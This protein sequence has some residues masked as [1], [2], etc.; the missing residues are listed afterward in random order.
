MFRVACLNIKTDKAI[1]LAHHV[2][3]KGYEATQI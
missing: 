3:D 1:E 2:M